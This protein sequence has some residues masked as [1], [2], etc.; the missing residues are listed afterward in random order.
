[1]LIP[2]CND[3]ILVKLPVIVLFLSYRWVYDKL[4]NHRVLSVID[5]SNWF[6]TSTHEVHQPRRVLPWDLE[7]LYEVSKADDVSEMHGGSRSSTRKM[8]ACRKRQRRREA[9]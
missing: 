1:M 6:K 9:I 8:S 5:D 4:E 3:V 2:T 7:M